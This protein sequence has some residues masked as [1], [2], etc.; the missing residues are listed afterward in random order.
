MSFDDSSQTRPLH[1]HGDHLKPLTATFCNAKISGHGED[2]EPV[3][4]LRYT[5]FVHAGALAVFDGLGG[6]GS[7][8]YT[9]QQ[10]REYTGAKIAADTTSKA[11][12]RFAE[13]VM[14]D[15]PSRH[16]D[17][18]ATRLDLLRNQFFASLHIARE[19]YT[20]RPT[21]LRSAMRRVLP[22][23]CASAV[24]INTDRSCRCNIIW[25]GDS[26]VYALSAT[27]L[28][29]L[30]L[31]DVQRNSTILDRP[32]EM[33]DAPITNCIEFGKDFVLN[34]L[35][36][37][38]ELPVILIAATDGCFGYLK[39]PV[40]FEHLLLDELQLSQSMEEW[41][42]RAADAIGQYAQDDYSMSITCCGWS[43]FQDVRA[44]FS[45]RYSHLDTMIEHYTADVNAIS[46]Y[47]EW[48]EYSTHYIARLKEASHGN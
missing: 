46:R 3:N 16:R 8:R 22:T 23:T 2:A 32:M 38:F 13:S 42:S 35:H 28:Q 34:H 47:P 30:T 37:T 1:L 41:R 4:I 39:T 36:H 20:P 44:T 21:Q 40:H 5:D 18:F 11:F 26:R 10:N 31:D 25:A 33:V 17:D 45:A 27:G 19:S 15:T 43:E 7:E 12:K 48:N 29:L 9:D 24:F 14:L 6:A